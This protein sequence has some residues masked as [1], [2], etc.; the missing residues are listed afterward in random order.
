[1]QL[2]IAVE[3]TCSRHLQSSGSLKCYQRLNRHPCLQVALGFAS[4]DILIADIAHCA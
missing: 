3:R 1:M 2:S 4:A